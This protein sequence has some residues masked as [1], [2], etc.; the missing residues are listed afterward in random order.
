[1]AE[2]E[3]VL[4]IIPLPN[5]HRK[6]MT[7]VVIAAI[8]TQEVANIHEPLLVPKLI[9]I[10]ADYKRKTNLSMQNQNSLTKIKLKTKL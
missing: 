6:T 1:M 8:Y 5:V 7:K 3:S 2:D 10:L 4:N 9:L